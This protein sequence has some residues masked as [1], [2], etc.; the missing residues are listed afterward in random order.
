MQESE[1]NTWGRSTG[2]HRF[3]MKGWISCAPFERLLNIE[4]VE[5]SDGQ[6]ELKMPFFMEYAQGGGL[7]HG[8]A[9]V[10][11]ADTAVV[12]AIKTRIPAQ[13]HFATIQMES[14][15]LSPVTKGTVTAKARLA[16]R[17]GRL[18]KGEA[19]LYN[20]DGRIVMEFSTTFKMARD[21]AIRGITFETQGSG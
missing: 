21:T 16:E 14:R 10:A 9:L 12:M 13:S 1:K 7:M 4:I 19:T 6:A 20:E 8:G 5:A 11:L 15:F 18:L 17:E 3:K 2:P